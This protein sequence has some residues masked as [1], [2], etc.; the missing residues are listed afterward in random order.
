LRGRRVPKRGAPRDP[1]R[2]H[3]GLTLAVLVSAGLA[4]S[5]LQTMILPALPALQHHYD[6]EPPAVRWVVTIFL[7]A[8]SIATPI[9]GRLGDMFGKDRMLVAVLVTFGLGSLLCALAPSLEL[10]VAGRAVQ[11]T[12]G[13]IFPLAFAIISDEFPRRLVTLGIGLMSAVH[14][15]GG[16][17]GLVISGVIVDHV[18]YTWIFWLAL[19]VTVPGVIA[20]RRFVPASPVTSPARVDW[21]GA[22][23][24]SLGLG[25]ALFAVTKLSAW[26][27]ASP[28]VLG[29]LAVAAAVAVV[30]VRL[31][32][33]VPEPL[34]DMRVMR[35]R[36]VWT[37]NV[38]GLVL[39]CGMLT[40]ILLLPQFV[41]A[42]ASTGF[43][44]GATATQAGLYLVP[45][46]LTIV[47]AAPLAGW[48][49]ARLGSRIPLLIGIAVGFAGYVQIVLWHSEPWHIYAHGVANGIAVGMAFAATV[50]LIVGAVPLTHTGLA[51]GMNMI[52]R[53]VG[54]ALQAQG[55]GAILAAT[56][57]AAGVLTSAG[58]Q[59]AFLASAGLMVVAFAV[60]LLVP[61]P[62]RRSEAAPYPAGE[63]VAS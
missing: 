35:L 49:G 30:W 46:S 2:Q 7:I 38:V 55:S 1:Q 16:A 23:L 63:V 11:G 32:Q 18:D 17:A 27:F 52:M 25:L 53:S 60:A 9:F 5:L 61:P 59:A 45:Q 44:F 43:G 39:G 8:A 19:I 10:L 51:T 36:A 48:L 12:G 4:F 37:T 6:A 41:Q 57:T 15:L 47:L 24:M 56:A 26:G 20:T 14:G 62:R 31:E 22:L 3:Y 13:A 21:A 58:F 34:V 50:N 42:P 29:L 33:R 40:S 54:G 28:R